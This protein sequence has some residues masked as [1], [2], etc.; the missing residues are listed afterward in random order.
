[1][2]GKKRPRPTVTIQHDWSGR[3]RTQYSQP[4][5]HTCALQIYER[6]SIALA[7]YSV[8]QFPLK[9]ENLGV[10]QWHSVDLRLGRSTIAKRTFMG[11]VNLTTYRRKEAL[12]AAFK[13]QPLD[14]ILPWRQFEARE[15]CGGRS[16][17][18]ACRRCCRW[19][20]GLRG[21]VALIQVT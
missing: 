5:P 19:R 1:M 14:A 4:K 8:R 11:V 12:L 20:R 13:R 17:G 6:V 16:D 3:D 15:A 2:E 7:P 21:N 10:E 9:R 18:V